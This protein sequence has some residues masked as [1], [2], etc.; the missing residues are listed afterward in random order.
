M[1]GI[2]S[3]ESSVT[4]KESVGA[5]TLKNGWLAAEVQFQAGCC[6]DLDGNGIG[7]FFVDG[8]QVAGVVVDPYLVLSGAQT[9][10]NQN[11]IQLSLLAAIFGISTGPCTSASADS[12][13][14]QQSNSRVWP[15]VG[16][17]V[18]M[19]PATAIA[20][21]ERAWCILSFPV[22]DQQCRRGFPN[23]TSGNSSASRLS[24]FD[25][26][27]AITIGGIA[28]PTTGSSSPVGISMSIAPPTGCIS[29]TVVDGA[30]VRR[31]G[32]WAA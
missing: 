14:S 23:N 29:R 8:I 13:V 3:M 18:F 30:A 22:D 2:A 15:S 31:A 12:V 9:M 21:G 4:S 25:S 17:D 1:I 16:G 26:D 11:H 10:G 32:M 27:G 20:P 6:T 7:S 24:E 19:T 28:M 5:S